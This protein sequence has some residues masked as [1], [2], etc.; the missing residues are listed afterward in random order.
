MS[1]SAMYAYNAKTGLQGSRHV[2]R[3]VER[4]RKL[5]YDLQR[6]GAGASPTPEEL[7]A[8]PLIENWTFMARPAPV[9]I[10]RITGHPLLSNQ[11]LLSVTSD[12]WIDG[13]PCGWV[14]TFSR[15]Y[16]LGSPLNGS[17]DLSSI[18][19]REVPN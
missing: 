2:H 19:D 10:G 17:I 9:L 4:F 11:S 1:E 6:V 8:A 12:V 18:H 15:Y 13:S 16:R 5:A 7:E 14:R 3:D